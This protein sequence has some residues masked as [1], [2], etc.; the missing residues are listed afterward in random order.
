[1]M[2]VAGLRDGSTVHG[3]R[4]MAWLVVKLASPKLK[5]KHNITKI[6]RGK[7]RGRHGEDGQDLSNVE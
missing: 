3:S 7:E 1:M 4:C 5:T 6:G 2:S